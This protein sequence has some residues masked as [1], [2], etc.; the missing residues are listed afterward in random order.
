M[1]KIIFTNQKGPVAVTPYTVRSYK[2][3]GP[4]KC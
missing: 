4:E 2:K 3:T 1:N